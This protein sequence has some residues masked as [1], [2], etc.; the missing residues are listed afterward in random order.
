MT[1]VIDTD[2]FQVRN[3]QSS[4]V[5]R[6]TVD[7]EGF[8]PPELLSKDFDTSN[9]TEIHDRFRLGVLIHYLL[10][11]YHPFFGNWTGVGESPEQTELIKQ[12]YW[13]AAYNS[14]IRASKTT[15]PLDVVHPELK[16]LFLK[17]FN[18]GHTKPHLRPTALDWHNTLEVAVNEL[19]VCNQVDSHHYSKHYGK[20][21]WCDRV[22]N[23]GVDIFPGGIGKARIPSKKSET[24]KYQKDDRALGDITQ[25]YFPKKPPSSSSQ[26]THQNYQSK[27]QVFKQNSTQLSQVAQTAPSI[28]VKH[29]NKLLIASAAILVA[30]SKIAIYGLTTSYLQTKAEEKQAE[31][32][33]QQLP[34]QRDLAE[35]EIEEY[36]VGAGI[37][38]TKDKNKFPMVTE[39]FKDSSAYKKGIK[40]DDRILKVN[41]KSTANK[42]LDYVTSLIRGEVNTQVTLK[43]ARLGQ[44]NQNFKLT[45]SRFRNDNIAESYFNRGN[46]RL[47]LKDYRAA[48]EDY[49]QAIL[50]N[51]D[52]ADAYNNRGDIL[53]NHLGD[54]Q[55]AIRDFQKAANLGDE[56]ARKNLKII[57]G[58]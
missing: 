45:R 12:G 54:R 14:P 36:I 21:C 49:T 10:F 56:V 52:Y 41:G 38:L 8:T 18:E 57:Q 53:H 28:I 34:Q 48:I 58:E 27:S 25:K 24:I 13:Y 7:S 50:L 40:V 26:T 11:G 29:K 22:A 35:R 42:D 3:P 20:C 2:S 43:I 33:K 5:Y 19:T 31:A 6:C 30:F 47:D 9:Q 39:V 15:I 32:E 46:I 1:A 16:K 23:L 17:C 51:S 37:S 55:G 4:K 44:K